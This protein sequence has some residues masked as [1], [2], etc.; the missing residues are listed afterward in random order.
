MECAVAAVKQ[1]WKGG[2]EKAK[3]LLTYRT[4]PLQ[5]G[6][7]PT[8]LLMGRQVPYTIPQLRMTLLPRWQNIREFR[9]VEKHNLHLSF[10]NKA[11]VMEFESDLSKKK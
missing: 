3:V 5:S 6:Y 9:K 4:T 1:L 11:D 7:S 2:G 10:P 8:Q